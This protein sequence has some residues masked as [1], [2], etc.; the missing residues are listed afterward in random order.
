MIPVT[1]VPQ[2]LDFV[3]EVQAPGSDWLAANP[4]NLDTSKYPPF[5]LTGGGGR[6]RQALKQ[7]FDYRCGYTTHRS[8]HATVDHFYSKVNGFLSG[9]IQQ[10]SQSMTGNGSTPT[11]CNKGGLNSSYQRWN[12]D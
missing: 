6:H 1:V 7:G 4:G 3:A 12:Y 5:W 2:P 10:K 9:S 11:G 8:D